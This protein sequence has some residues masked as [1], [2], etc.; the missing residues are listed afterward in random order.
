MN[1]RPKEMST[2]NG[3]VRGKEDSWLMQREVISI[4][5]LKKGE[6]DRDEEE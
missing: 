6:K 5:R 1:E 4:D 2:V 3:W